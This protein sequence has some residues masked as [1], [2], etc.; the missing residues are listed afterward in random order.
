M[1]PDGCAVDPHGITNR[2]KSEVAERPPESWTPLAEDLEDRSWQ[3]IQGTSKQHLSELFS[4]LQQRVGAVALIP[5]RTFGFDHFSFWSFS[6]Q[7]I[8]ESLNNSK[9]LCIFR[10]GGGCWHHTHQA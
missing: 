4:N 3:N 9:M 10:L 2:F 5:S 1:F 8:G 6:T 7:I